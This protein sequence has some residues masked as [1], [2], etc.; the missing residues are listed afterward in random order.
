MNHRLIA[1][2][3][4]WPLS[5]PFRIARG[6][7]DAADVVVAEVREGEAVGLGEAAPYARYGES[8]ASV[9][10]QVESLSADVSREALQRALPPGAARNAV[11]CALWDLQAKLERRGVAS[12][13][14]VA[15]PREMITAVTVSLDSIERMAEAAARA[16]APLLKVK[17]DAEDPIARVKAV[18]L[19]APDARLIVDPNESWSP[20][21]LL[22]LLPELAR[23]DVA[24]IEQP[25]PASQGGALEG[26]KPPVPICGDEAVHITT[27]LER[28]ARR[29]QAVNIKLDKAGGLTE[30]L[31]M[32][33]RAD[34]M[35][36]TVM[37]GCMVCTS[38]AVLPALL[39][40]EG[41]AFID[42]DGPWWMAK[43][44]PDAVQIANGVLTPP[45]TGWGLP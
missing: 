32:R 13:A 21:L 7:K 42:L 17:V 9:V 2:S 39:I 23:L 33:R 44:R 31:T 16:R 8:V 25:V 38:L 6:V 30:A 37:V 20:A 26:L 24:L 4:R 29:Y 19:T 34:E 43:D 22:E 18:R 12:I 10:A 1:R 28:A 3:E 45:S 14:G 35:G 27:D 36:L 5:R 41:A 15:A 11:D 40:A